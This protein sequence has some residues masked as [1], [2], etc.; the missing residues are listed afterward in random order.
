MLIY[1][2]AILAALGLLAL[3]LRRGERH[4]CVL[5]GGRNGRHRDKCG[6]PAFTSSAE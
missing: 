3:A 1:A 4:S 6:L 2:V 5:C